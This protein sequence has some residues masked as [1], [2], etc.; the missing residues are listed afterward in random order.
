MSQ[1]ISITELT[2]AA[3]QTGSISLGSIIY[4]ALKP[5]IK[6]YLIIA[7]GFF[8]ARRNVLTIDT[9]RNISFMIVSVL[10][11]ALSFSKVVANIDDSFFEKFCSILISSCLIIFGQGILTFAVGLLAGCPRNWWGG[12]LMC[13]M[14]PNIGDIPIA[15]LQGMES[16]NVFENPE[17]GVA[18]IILYGAIQNFVQFNLGAYRIVGIDFE[19]DKK[20]E[21]QARDVESQRP[22]LEALSSTLNSEQDSIQSFDSFSDNN[23]NNRDNDNV[24]GT[25]TSLPQVGYGAIDDS[26]GDDSFSNS[27]VQRYSASSGARVISRKASINTIFDNDL[28][29]LPTENMNDLVKVFSR[30]RRNTTVNEHRPF[31]S[32]SRSSMSVP[33]VKKSKNFESRAR[34]LFSTFM[35]TFIENSLKP[36]SLGIVISLTVALTP[37]LKALFV[38]TGSEHVHPTPDN[39]PPLSVL[40][41]F[42]AYLGN[43][44]W[45]LPY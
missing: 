36:A 41:D 22:N 28:R 3:Q 37:W 26:N 17:L 24:P 27:Q 45:L 21:K 42:A 39:Q 13:G 4:I 32:I 19:Y 8:L 7:V 9:T 34:E 40:L 25:R 16:S 5:I 6:I 20:M 30:S 11:P 43:A 14:F 29:E 33:Q 2:T 10:G 15:Y 44:Q 1:L 31:T 38:D 12:L 18:Y 35:D 23:N